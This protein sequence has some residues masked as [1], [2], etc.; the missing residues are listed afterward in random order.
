MSKKMQWLNDLI[1]NKRPA[2]VMRLWSNAA[3]QHLVCVTCSNIIL[4]PFSS[5]STSTLK[6]ALGSLKVIEN[7]RLYTGGFTRLRV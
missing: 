6:P 7:G 2:I 4:A 3:D 1:K 5:H